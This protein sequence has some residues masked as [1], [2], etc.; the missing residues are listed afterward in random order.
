MRAVVTVV[1]K[2]K[3][4]IIAR[5]SGLFYDFDKG[6]ASYEAPGGL[7]EGEIVSKWQYKIRR[8]KMI[9]EFESDVKI[10]DDILKQ[11]LG[12]SGDNQLKSIVRTIQKE[13]NAIIRNIIFTI[14]G[15]SIINVIS[16]DDVGIVIC[17]FI[18]TNIIISM[19]RLFIP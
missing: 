18:S 16:F 3:T 13:Q 19:T 10:D 8:G 4:G 15:A 17:S 11:E 5:V 9:Y 2:D 12:N 1:G 6:P 7:M 14:N